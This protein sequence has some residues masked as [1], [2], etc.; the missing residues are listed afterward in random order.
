MIIISAQS[1][2]PALTGLAKV[3]SHRGSIECLRC[4]RVDASP[5]R[6]TL[7]G[8]DLDLTANIVLP[9]AD[10]GSTASF[11]LPLDRLQAFVRRVQSR[12]VLCLEPGCIS[13]D[14]GTGRI[15]EDVACPA[16]E[17][18]PA[19]PT[20]TA[21]CVSLPSS[22]P[23]RFAEAMSCSS[24]DQ[25]R[26]V[27]NGI[28]LD[29][30]QPGSHY[31]VGT[32]GRH[33]FS[34]NSFTL[35]LEAS[36]I[37]PNHKLLTWRGL[38]DLPWSMASETKAGK[39]TLRIIAGNW[40]ITT[41]TVDGQ[42]PN[43]RQVIPKEADRRTRVT[44]PEEHDFNRIVNGLPGGNAEDK[45]V[46]LVIES[47]GVWIKDLA[48]GANLRLDGAKASGPDLTVRLN[49]DYLTKAFDFGLTEIGFV[50]ALAP[51][52]FTREGRQLVVMPLRVS[53]GKSPSQP[54][55]QTTPSEPQPKKTDMPNSTE[56]PSE[57]PRSQTP[58]TPET[59]IPCLEA[60]IDQLDAFKATFREALA[61]LSDLN[62]L[63]RQA[64]KEQRTT[65]KEVHQV[66]QTLRSLQSVRI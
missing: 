43:W 34:A 33:L 44:M 46:D 64:V 40:T 4:I 1:L 17:E 54:T 59:E 37:V 30:S 10:C 56:K 28:G 42:Y 66:R 53:T 14:L 52:T 35:P 65:K 49:R 21:E 47:G 20:F 23:S 25:T 7:S 55:K 22:F 9:E 32:D 2:K 36:L 57:T 41:K 48:G 12:S 39:S 38:S 27:L 45:P 11:L 62:A 63:L 24:T 26:Y 18:F 19:I 8:T 50:D 51:L 16:V 6:V 60:A 31:L 61:G 15:A 5:D 3:I 29:V 13:C 58:D